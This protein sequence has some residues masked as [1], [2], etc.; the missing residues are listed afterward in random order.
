MAFETYHPRMRTKE[1][2]KPIVRFSKN[3]IVLNKVAREELKSPEY[4]ELAFDKDTSSI[5]IRHSVKLGGIP[6]K[7]TK[8]LAKGFFQYFDIN[9]QG[10]YFAN[11]DP[12]DNAL[13]VGIA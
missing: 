13:F 1:G 12:G 5:R 2:P 6:L 7:K 8:V 3:S 4:I 9:V 11:Y 10:N